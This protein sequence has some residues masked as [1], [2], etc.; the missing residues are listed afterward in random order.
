MVWYGMAQAP[1]SQTPGAAA[2]CAKTSTWYTKGLVGIP[3]ATY[4]NVASAGD[5][6]AAANRPPLNF[7]SGI[8]WSYHAKSK[9]CS[10]SYVDACVACVVRTAGL[11][12]L[13]LKQYAPCTMYE[14]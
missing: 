5:C 6:C 12:S 1:P 7:Y 14:A 13:S 4:P 3:V 8:G 9:E 10:I 2:T 11:P